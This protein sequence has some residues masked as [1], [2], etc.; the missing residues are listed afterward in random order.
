[1]DMVDDVQAMMRGCSHLSKRRGSFCLGGPALAGRDGRMARRN[2]PLDRRA[3][4]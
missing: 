1:M 3:A 4:P 2:I